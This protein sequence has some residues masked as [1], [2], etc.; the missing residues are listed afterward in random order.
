MA[1][2]S[3]NGPRG[4]QRRRRGQGVEGRPP[5][6][7][8][9]ARLTAVAPG[10]GLGEHKRSLIETALL[11]TLIEESGHGYALV[12]RAAADG[13]QLRVDSRQHLSCCA[14]WRRPG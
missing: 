1:N 8:D 9:A 5:R 14:H 2:M 7:P 11:I 13:D 6:G 12:E 4:M 3:A 10:A